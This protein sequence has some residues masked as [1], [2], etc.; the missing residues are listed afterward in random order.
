MWLIDVRT[1][2]LSTLNAPRRNFGVVGVGG[3]SLEHT[4]F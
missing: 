2:A 1:Y 4:L 3:P